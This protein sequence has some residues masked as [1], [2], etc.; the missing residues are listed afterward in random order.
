MTETQTSL[1]SRGESA[2]PAQAP[3]EIKVKIPNATQVPTVLRL[4]VPPGKQIIENGV[5]TEERIIIILRKDKPLVVNGH[6]TIFP[7]DVAIEVT[8][9]ALRT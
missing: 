1:K 9:S 2:P 7:Y 5:P 8:K 3:A 4:E 6:T